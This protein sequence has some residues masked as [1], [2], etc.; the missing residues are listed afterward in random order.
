MPQKKGFNR[1][2][3]AEAKRVGSLVG[4]DIAACACKKK[5]CGPGPD[6]LVQDKRFFVLRLLSHIE[7]LLEDCSACLPAAVLDWYKEAKDAALEYARMEESLYPILR[8]T[9]KRVEQGEQ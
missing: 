2:D 5:S 4:F 9:K 1:L 7:T 3:I 8:Q 6:W